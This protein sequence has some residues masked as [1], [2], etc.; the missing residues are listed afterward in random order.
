MVEAFARADGKKAWEHRIE[1]TGDLPENH[2]KHNL[3]TP[4]PITDGERIYAWFGKRTSAC[5]RHAGVSPPSFS[6]RVSST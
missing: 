4:T 3:A 1:A 5:S 6:T 2:E